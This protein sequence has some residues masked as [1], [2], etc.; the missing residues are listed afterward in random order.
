MGKTYYVKR[1]IKRGL[2]GWRVSRNW[3]N[4]FPQVLIHSTQLHLL[5]TCVCPPKRARSLPQGQPEGCGGWCRS[6]GTPFHLIAVEVRRCSSFLQTTIM[7]VLQAP[8]WQLSLL[9][10]R[11]LS[12]KGKISENA[13]VR[14]EMFQEGVKLIS[15]LMNYKPIDAQLLFWISFLM[16]PC[17]QF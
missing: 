9:F 10:S 14:S 1:P 5:S 6:S 13:Q 8:L 2:W 15:W 3:P 7:T 11:Y 17:F 12:Q 16:F 4:H